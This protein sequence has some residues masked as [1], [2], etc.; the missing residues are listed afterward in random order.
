MKIA[1]PYRKDMDFAFFVVNFGYSKSDY[2]ALTPKEKAFI[3][4]AWENK[5]VSDMCSIY[6]ACYTA[7]FNANRSKKQRA[8]K[9]LKKKEQAVDENVLSENKAVIKQADKN[10]GDWIAKI[11]KANGLPYKR[12]LAVNA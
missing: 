11:Y 2:E 5:K 1:G 7:F 8:I 6:N 3:Y 4:K 9:L 10:D 12:R